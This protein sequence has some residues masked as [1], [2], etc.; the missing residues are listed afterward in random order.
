V[1]GEADGLWFS[2]SWFGLKIDICSLAISKFRCGDE[3]FM[4]SR[5][6]VI[7]TWSGSVF[8][9][10]SGA[11]PATDR[12]R[13]GLAADN[14]PDTDPDGDCPVCVFNFID[15]PRFGAVLLGVL[16][17]LPGRAELAALPFSEP[18][19]LDVPV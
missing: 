7:T 15:I 2:I 1:Y 3:E 4:F 18:L 14:V 17:A 8:C 13:G 10:E 5:V 16:H 6:G 9:T 19:R 12:G 11:V